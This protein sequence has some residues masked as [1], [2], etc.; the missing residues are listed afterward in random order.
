MEAKREIAKIKIIITNTYITLIER[1][2]ELVEDR[3]KLRL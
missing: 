3:M 2:K 1:Y